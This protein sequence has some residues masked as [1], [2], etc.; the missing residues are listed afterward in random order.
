MWVYIRRFSR[1]RQAGLGPNLG[2][3][4]RQRTP[5]W[6]DGRPGGAAGPPQRRGKLETCFDYD[7][8]FAIAFDQIIDL[9]G[10]VG[11]IF[12]EFSHIVDQKVCLGAH[13][14]IVGDIHIDTTADIEGK[15]ILVGFRVVAYHHCLVSGSDCDIWLDQTQI[16]PDNRIQYDDEFIV[17]PIGNGIGEDRIGRY[18]DLGKEV[19]LG[20][21][22]GKVVIPFLLL[23]AGIGIIPYQTE[24]ESA[25]GSRWNGHCGSE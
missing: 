18:T 10:I 16:R 12:E 25:W 17:V 2:G 3:R 8:D 9:I 4:E 11:D 13:G 6:R 24:I 23:Q 19:P 20:S 7:T 15:G 1:Q 14:D 21:E 5:Y 22:T